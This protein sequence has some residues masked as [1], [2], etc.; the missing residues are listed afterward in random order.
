[1]LT[2]QERTELKAE[3][4]AFV[5]QAQAFETLAGNEGAPQVAIVGAAVALA[6]KALALAVQA[7]GDVAG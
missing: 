1:M 4:A 5:A 2:E 3:G 6:Q 7:A